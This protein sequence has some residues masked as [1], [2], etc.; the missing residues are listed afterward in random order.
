MNWYSIFYWLTVANNAKGFFWTFAIILTL[1]LVISVIAAAAGYDVPSE[2]EKRY[3]DVA[4][5]WAKWLIPFVMLVWAGIVFTPDRKDVILIIAGGSTANFLT[6]DSNAKAIPSEVMIFLQNEIRALAEEAKVEISDAKAD[7]RTKSIR[8]K[9][10]DEAKNMTGDQ[11]L[12]KMK[13]D[14]TFRNLILSN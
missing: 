13:V 3:K 5:S 10:L 7:L 14:T 2:K 9:I 4:R 1:C 6:S 11:I 12:E 8:E